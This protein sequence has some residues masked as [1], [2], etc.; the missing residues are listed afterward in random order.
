MVFL[1]RKRELNPENAALLIMGKR[2]FLFLMDGAKKGIGILFAPSIKIELNY[3]TY[4]SVELC[5]APNLLSVG[6]RS[7]HVVKHVKK[8]PIAPIFVEKVGKRE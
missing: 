6:R 1:L 5:K 4:R 8:P 7:F 2:R 3:L